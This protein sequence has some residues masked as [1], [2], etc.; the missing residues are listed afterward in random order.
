MELDTSENF[1][2]DIDFILSQNK[3]EL[4]PKEKRKLIRKLKKELE[5]LN[6]VSK[7]EKKFF[8]NNFRLEKIKTDLQTLLNN[9]EN[10][11]KIKYGNVNFNLEKEYFSKIKDKNNYLNYLYSRKMNSILKNYK[12]TD[13]K[14]LKIYGGL[15]SIYSRGLKNS[16]YKNSEV[17]ENSLNKLIAYKKSEIIDYELSDYLTELN[18]D[19][20]LGKDDEINEDDGGGESYETVITENIIDNELVGININFF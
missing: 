19:F 5:V 2:A 15:I 7:K 18:N 3:K 9:N 16:K 17:I 8:Q 6:K 20:F 14:S 11:I 10:K 1:N 4:Q 13:K 12:L